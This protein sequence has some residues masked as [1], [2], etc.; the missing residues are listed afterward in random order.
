MKDID[1]DMEVLPLCNLL[2]YNRDNINEIGFVA[3]YK[4]NR[5]G[6]AINP[7][8]LKDYLITWMV[9][10][11]DVRSH[12]IIDKVIAYKDN[13]SLGYVIDYCQLEEHLK[14]NDGNIVIK[15]E[16]TKIGQEG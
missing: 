3:K 8:K 11:K 13:A 1:I 2:S 5:T 15:V 10:Y 12:K 16:L 14:R 4:D 9:E 6:K 7:I